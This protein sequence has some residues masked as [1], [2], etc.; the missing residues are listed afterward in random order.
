MAQRKIGASWWV[1][2]TFQ[3]KRYRKR[4]P[5]NTKVGAQAYEATLRHNLAEGVSLGN[6]QD[7]KQ[8]QLF[9]DFAN[10]WFKTH[11]EVHNKPAT[12]AKAN[13]ILKRK[14]IP[15]FGNTPLNKLTTLQVEEYKAKAKSLGLVNKTINNELC[16]LSKCL[17]DAKRWYKLEA[18]PD[19]VMLKVPP[20]NYDFITE[21]ESKQL[22]KHLLSLIHI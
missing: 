6:K 1:D 18:L 20:T 4:S 14:L 11:V 9:K 2:I 7:E 22:L 17:N 21:D 19:I 8:Q 13:S 10:F 3:G 12:I 5:A 16:I 15:A